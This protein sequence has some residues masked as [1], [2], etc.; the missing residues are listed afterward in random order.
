MPPPDTPAAGAPPRLS[1]NRPRLFRSSIFRLTLVYLCLSS[2]SVL[3]VVGTI[4]WVATGSLTRQID[5]TIDAEITAL[6]E[7]FDQRGLPGLVRAIE[8]RSDRA[9]GIGGLYLL[10]DARRVPLAG[11]LDRWPD[12]APDDQGWVTFPLDYASADGGGINFGRAR[13]F[14][15]GSWFL[16]VGHDVRERL[17]VSAHIRETLVIGIVL[18]IGL[19]LLGGIL[20]SR[21]LLARIEAI[22]RTSRE[23][24]AGDLTRRVP[25]GGGSDEFD[26]LAENLNAMLARIEQLLNSLKQVGDNIAHD[27]RSPLTRMR[28]RLEVALMGAG[29]LEASR[30]AIRETIAEADRLLQIFNALLGI[31]RIEAGAARRDFARFRL[32]PLLTDVAELYEPLAEARGQSLTLTIDPEVAAD[33]AVL[34]GRDLLSQAVANLVDNAIKFTPGG[35]A[36]T[37]SLAR[38]DGGYGLAVADSGPGIPA[39][40]RARAV[41]RFYR[42]ESSRSTA[43]SGLGLSL[44]AAVA[45]LHGGRLVLED[46]R[47]G[48]VARLTLPANGGPPG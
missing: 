34:G 30:V 3:G 42:L 10:A 47:P 2:A 25:T 36:V 27:L 11:N 22:N 41:E 43:G 45:E 37:V 32:A 35:G 5:A 29:D 13:V 48:L 16:L 7:Q 39:A 1:A 8:R 28:G 15:L 14:R 12:I 38:E 20:M 17:L 24:M 26:Q 9:Q 46:N 4:Y 31:A 18:T 44:V 40:L 21:R 33:A 19:S 23:I 6:A